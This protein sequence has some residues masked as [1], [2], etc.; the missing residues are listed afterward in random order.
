MK[1]RIVLLI[2][3][4][5]TTV[6]AGCGDSERAKVVKS[7]NE[8]QESYRQAQASI[9]DSRQQDYQ[10]LGESIQ[11]L[12]ELAEKDSGELETQEELA[13]AENL[14]EEFYVQLS[15]LTYAIE[16]EKESQEEDRAKFQVTFRNDSQ[17][18]LASLTIHDPEKNM[19]TEIDSFESGKS[20]DTTVTVD[21]E[22][23]SF[24]WY[25]YN[26]AGECVLETTSSFVD[27]KQGIIIYYTADGVYTE[28]Y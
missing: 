8:L 24:A 26:E 12:S 6:L 27:A 2:L 16:E 5:L 21:V 1:K 25:L 15:E 11:A 18:N 23:L 22:E 10:V 14:V 7:I 20:I 3:L 17:E 19:E 28:S 13:E 4:G 9:P